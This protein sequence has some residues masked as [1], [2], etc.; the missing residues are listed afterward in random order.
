MIVFISPKYGKCI[1]WGVC[2]NG[3]EKHFHNIEIDIVWCG[4]YYLCIG[5]AKL[6]IEF[7][8]AE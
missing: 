1:Q 7:L 4:V 2:V 5:K 6:F 3:H 8:Q